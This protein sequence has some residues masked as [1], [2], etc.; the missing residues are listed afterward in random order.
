MAGDQA[1]TARAI[2]DLLAS[3]PMRA[4]MQHKARDYYRANFGSDRYFNTMDSVME[5]LGFTSETTPIKEGMQ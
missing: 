3:E 4:R 5:S 1:G 2:L